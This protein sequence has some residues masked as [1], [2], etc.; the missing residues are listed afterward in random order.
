[1]DERL[2]GLR[3]DEKTAC[4]VAERATGGWAE[5]WDGNGREG[6]RPPARM[7]AFEIAEGGRQMLV[8]QR[9]GDLCN[10]QHPELD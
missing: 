7:C 4:I 6:V 8:E 3:N 9:Q 10:I 5:P 2:A 1:M